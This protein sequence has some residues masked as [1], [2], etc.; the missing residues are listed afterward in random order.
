MVSIS[1]SRDGV[2]VVA[3]FLDN[4]LVTFNLDTKAKNKIVHSTIPY[5][6]SWGSHIVAAGNDGKIAF[7]EP[8][9]DC[10]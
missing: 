2:N 9:G 3:G 1:A 4:S 6:L 10:F 8:S 7:Y 5:A